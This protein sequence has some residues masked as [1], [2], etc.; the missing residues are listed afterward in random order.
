MGDLGQRGVLWGLQRHGVVDCR[1]PTGYW[2]AAHVSITD[3]CGCCSLHPG[4]GWLVGWSKS[5]CKSGRLPGD[6]APNTKAEAGS[7]CGG[8]CSKSGTDESVL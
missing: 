2:T 8:H 6:A 1:T 4:L 3:F 5:R 7:V